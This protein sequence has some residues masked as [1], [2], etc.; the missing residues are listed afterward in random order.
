MI[1]CS[2]LLARVS[3]SNIPFDSTPAFKHSGDETKI[4][5]EEPRASSLGQP[6]CI[7]FSATRDTKNSSTKLQYHRIVREKHL[8][9]REIPWSG[10]FLAEVVICKRNVFTTL[11]LRC[12]STS[13][14]V[15]VSLFEILYLKKG[16]AIVASSGEPF[17]FFRD[18]QFLYR[19]SVRRNYNDLRHG[20]MMPLLIT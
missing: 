3:Y 11:V 20:F 9:K 18:F 19:M 8:Q 13:F 16:V 4:E 1:R 2:K 10:C 14:P 17:F 5:T 7:H 6:Q 12:F 15:V